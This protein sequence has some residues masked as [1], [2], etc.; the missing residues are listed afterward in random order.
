MLDV[1]PIDETLYDKLQIF[2]NE[3]NKLGYKN[4]ASFE[5]MK[6]EWCKNWGEFFCIVIDNKIVSVSGCH[7]LPEVDNT[8]WRIFFRSCVLPKSLPFKGL[9]KG[10]N[11]KT[12]LYINKF[13]EYCPTNELYITTNVQNNEY[14]HIL[15]YHR[16][17]E[18]ESK[19]KNAHIKQV[20]QMK[21]YET[22]Q[23]IWK[24]N[25]ERFKEKYG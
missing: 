5:A 13:I 18:L 10:T 22:D 9:H 24:L 1:V 3:C 7:P 20:G 8:A 19:Q 6:L 15:R 23:T 25:I 16:S 17:L 11:I 2:C 4:N 12:R 14:K 21:L